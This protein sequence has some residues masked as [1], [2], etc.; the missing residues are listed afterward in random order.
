M[1]PFGL[2]DDYTDDQGFHWRT[3]QS[4]QLLRTSPSASHH[5]WLFFNGEWGA[6]KSSWLATHAPYGPFFKDCFHKG[7]KMMRYAQCE[8]D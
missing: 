3:W 5:L 6:K 4:L 1:L 7:D 2:I 8:H